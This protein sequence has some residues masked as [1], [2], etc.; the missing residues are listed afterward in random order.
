MKT[1]IDIPENVL[2]EAMRLTGAETKKE[3]VL[4]ALEVLIRQMRAAEVA[5]MLG[6]FEDIW[7]AEDL[8][9]H[10]EEE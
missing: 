3:A 2:R 1:T 10:R 4:S 8:A 5:K 9:K 6:T 7:S